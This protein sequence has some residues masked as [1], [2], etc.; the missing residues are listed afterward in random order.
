MGVTLYSGRDGDLQRVLTTYRHSSGN[1]CVYGQD[2][3]KGYEYEYAFT[4]SEADESKL[5]TALAEALN[6]EGSAATGS[7]F[8]DLQTAFRTGMLD[9]ATWTDF[10]KDH[11]IECEFW[12]RWDD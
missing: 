9:S 3:G 10:L 12:S 5:T 8:D 1:L 6:A 11:G 2:L 7:I 4:F